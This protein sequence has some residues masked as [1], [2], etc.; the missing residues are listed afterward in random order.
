MSF[1][2]IDGGGPGKDERERQRDQEWSEHEFS[3]AIRETAANMLRI[4]RGAGK[5]YELLVQMKKTIDSAIKYQE[6]HSH[7]PEISNYLQIEDE[8]H[9]HMERA[10]K[11]ELD[12]ATFDLWREDGTFERMMAE[13]TIMRGAFQ[14]V[15]SQLIGQRT[16]QTAGEQELHDG[17]RHWL[18][19][20]DERREKERLAAL[21]ARVAAPKKRKVRRQRKRKPAADVPL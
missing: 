2:V 19:I 15:A 4:V 7:W 9:R 8:H 20:R 1:K 13:N 10:Q 3:W 17:L 6:L 14:T 21:R 16:Q 11:G 18:R 12:K 5:P